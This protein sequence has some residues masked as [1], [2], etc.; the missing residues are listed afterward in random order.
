[1]RYG[2]NW[3]TVVLFCLTAVTV[4][5]LTPTRTRASGGRITS[6]SSASTAAPMILK[7]PACGPNVDA[8]CNCPLGADKITCNCYQSGIG[9]VGGPPIYG[10]GSA[11]SRSGSLAGGA[12]L[13]SMHSAHGSSE[14]T[15]RLN[16]SAEMPDAFAEVAMAFL[17]IFFGI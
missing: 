6:A 10:S 17:R 7:Q 14:G 13:S 4:L 5:C 3:S 12:S 15:I 2:M 8:P 1:M 9:C 16:R 11:V